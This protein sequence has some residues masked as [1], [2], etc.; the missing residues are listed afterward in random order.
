MVAQFL[1][2]VKGCVRNFMH[3]LLGMRR[4]MRVV[5]LQQPSGGFFGRLRLPLN[6]VRG[7][8][9]AAGCGGNGDAWTKGLRHSEA[10]P[11]AVESPMEEQCTPAVDARG[12]PP[13][14][15][16]SRS[17][18]PPWR[19]GR[20]V[21]GRGDQRSPSFRGHASG[22]G[23]PLPRLGREPSVADRGRKGGARER[24]QLSTQSGSGVER[25][26]RRRRGMAVRCRYREEPS[27]GFFGRFAPSE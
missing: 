1:A 5:T 10:T 19:A 2:S 13:P 3:F 18:D 6:D 27:V 24:A 20:C 9:C 15:S 22:R 8:E 7:D 4:G 17:G 26:L 14:P 25:T 16:S 12:S 21:R 11:V 23:I